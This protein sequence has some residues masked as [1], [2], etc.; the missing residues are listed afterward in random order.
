[1][2]VSNS[3]RK[4][5]L[6]GETAAVKDR[7]TTTR[8]FVEVQN[9]FSRE[10]S[11]A[12]GFGHYPKKGFFSFNYNFNKRR[13]GIPFNSNDHDPEVV[14]LNPRRHSIELR[15]GFRET[16]HFSKPE[17]SRCNTTT[18][19]MRKSIPTGEIDTAFKN[20]TALYQGMYRLR[21]D[22]QSSGRFGFWGQHRDF[23]ATAKKLGSAHKAKLVR[24]IWPP[25]LDF[26]A[27]RSSLAADS[28]QI[29][30]FLKPQTRGSFLTETSRV[31]RARPEFALNLER[32]CTRCQLFASISCAIP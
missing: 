9:S 2:A 32:R 4:R 14:Q 28:K 19:A 25:N 31:S 8:P 22:W 13:Y 7:A 10:A 16:V 24:G 20:N 3:A 27:C 6:F 21:E 23:S 30:T 17:H 18:T 5:W 29:V 15:G 11:A 1:M 26:Q 12:A